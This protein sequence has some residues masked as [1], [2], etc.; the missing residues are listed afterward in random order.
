M[1]K[2]TLRRTTAAAV[3]LALAASPLAVGA[4]ASTATAAPDRVASTSVD[5]TYLADT[6]GLPAD[7]VIETVT[8]DRFQWL[9]QQ[10]GQYAILIG[11]TTDAGFAAKA[12]QADLAAKAA[13]ASRIYWF[14]PN[15]SGQSGVKKLDVRNPATIQLAAA[16]QA[17]FAKTWQNVL[18]QYLGNG[19]KSVPNLAEPNRSASTSVTISNDDT[20]INDSVDPAWDYRSTQTPAVGPEDAVFF[21]YDKDRTVAAQPDKIADWVDLT[22]D[23]GVPAS[24]AAA[25]T[26]IGGGAVI[27][28]TTQYAWW[29]TYNNA[30][31][32]YLNPSEARYGG[33]ILDDSDNVGGFN[34]K[35]IT[36]PELLHLLDVKDSADKNFVILFG[37]T[38]CPNTRAVIKFLNREAKAN[39]VTVY[40]FDLVLDGGKVNGTNAGANPI[41]IRDNAYSGTTFNYRPSYLYGDLV[42][43]YL[44]NLVTEYD[45][46]GGNRVAFYPGGDLAAFPDV[47]RKLQVPFLVNYQRGTGANPSSTSIK[48]Q[49]I[50]QNVD[51]STGLPTFKEYMSQ[52]WFTNPSAQ[53]GLPFAIPADESTLTQAEQDQLAQARA[54]VAFG[55]E[56]LTKLRYFFGGLPG[57]VVS[58]QTITA[59]AVPFGTRPTV[60][61]AVANPYGRVPA[62]T[63]TLTVGG[64]SYPEA[65]VANGA[66]FE[67]DALPPG[68]Y[69]YTITYPGDAQVVAFEKAGTLTVTKAAVSSTVTTVVKAPTTVAGGSYRVDLTTPVGVGPATGGVEVTLSKGAVTRKATGVLANGTTTVALP[70]LPAGSWTTSVAYLGDVHVAAVTTV[71]KPV[72]STPAKVLA[73]TGSV[74]KAPTRAKPGSYQVVVRVPA[75]QR[76]ATGTVTLT[77][78]KG[79]QKV[80]I[81]GTLRKGVATL[82]V[83]RLARGAWAVRLAFGGDATYAAASTAGR[84]VTVA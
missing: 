41:H 44:R 33:D 68:D 83:P 28:Q 74:V 77:L 23:A 8:Y 67:V 76:A 10:P 4:V 80:K 58:T 79:A 63:A 47:V 55:Q 48:R 19:I 36:Y 61:L 60:T 26:A 81:V 38:W 6:L 34:V 2:H 17:A 69:P 62:G 22:T 78:V 66:V 25:F 7:T 54:N 46:N 37:G 24:I 65:L 53:I 11:S 35:Q 42:R 30:V 82:A 75:R 13:G 52:W 71:G 84:A 31:H 15:L 1:S 29:K 14:D 16:S 39:D 64:K 51:A 73:V 45:P 20:V 57:A 27:D 50:Q 40:N 3:G 43:K 49:W 32:K 59:P 18:G 5:T 56:A 21:V 70:A 9:L 72:V 12:V